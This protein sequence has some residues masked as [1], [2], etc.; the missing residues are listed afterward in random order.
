MVKF[1]ALRLHV[2]M[3]P[4]STGH[5]AHEENGDAQLAF[6]QLPPLCLCSACYACMLLGGGCSHPCVKEYRQEV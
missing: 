3:L 5:E 2:W 4:I 1:R 6:S